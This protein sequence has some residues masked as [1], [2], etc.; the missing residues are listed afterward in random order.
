MEFT[1]TL[2]E[3]PAIILLFGYYVNA[4]IVTNVIMRMQ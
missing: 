2:G 1:L 4:V 3:N